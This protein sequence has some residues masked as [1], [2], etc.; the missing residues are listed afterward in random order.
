MI[1]NIGGRIAGCHRRNGRGNQCAGGCIRPDDEL[2][3][4]PE[5]C[6]GDQRQDARVESD[7]R[8]EAGELRIGDADRQRHSRH[9]ESGGQIMGQVRAAVAHQIGYPRGDAPEAI[10]QGRQSCCH[11][12]IL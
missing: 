3:G 9:G 6:V 8:V 11:G 1:S 2:P 7:H 5:Q 4:R 12:P 10:E